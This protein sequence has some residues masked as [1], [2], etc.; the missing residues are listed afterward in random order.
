MTRPEPSSDEVRRRF[1]NQGR[2]D[3]EPELAIR[4]RLHAMGHRY[5]VDFAPLPDLKRRRADIVFTK[6]KVA[7][8]VDGCFW[9]RCPEHYV[10]PKSNA[11]WWEAKINANVERDRDTDARLVEAGWRVVRIWEHEDPEDAATRILEVLR[12]A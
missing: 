8:F 3:T 10:P 6:Q 7:V 11:E 2:R 5:R 9:H 1:E 4:R 12:S